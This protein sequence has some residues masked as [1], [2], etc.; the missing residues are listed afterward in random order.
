MVGPHACRFNSHVLYRLSYRGMRENEAKLFK[1]ISM[2]TVG[3]KVQKWELNEKYL[4]YK[5]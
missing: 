2:K 4:R 1:R 3:R 5:V